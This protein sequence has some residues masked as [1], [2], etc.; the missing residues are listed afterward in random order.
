M[1]RTGFRDSNA[2]ETAL[3]PA[4][5]NVYEGSFSL[6]GRVRILGCRKRAPSPRS[7]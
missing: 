5:L 4:A 3:T 2:S 6:Q 1:V 7:I